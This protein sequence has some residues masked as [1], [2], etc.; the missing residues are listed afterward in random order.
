MSAAE[1]LRTLLAAVPNLSDK[2]IVIGSAAIPGYKQPQQL[3]AMNFLLANGAH[4]DVVIN[5]DG[6]NEVALAPSEQVTK[7]IWHFYPR[8]WYYRVAD[9]SAQERRILGHLTHLRGKRAELARKFSGPLLRLS[10]TG[11]LLWH[12]LDARL[13]RQSAGLELELL[14]SETTAEDY[15]TRGPSLTPD[16]EE[17]LYRELAE[18]WWRSSMLMN[19]LSSENGMRYFHF[20][21]PNQYVEGSKPLS[22]E[23]RRRAFRGR[24]PYRRGVVLGY[25]ELLAQAQQSRTTKIAFHDLTGLFEGLR[26]TLYVDSCCHFNHKGNRLLA[27]AVAAVMRE[28]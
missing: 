27:E 14:E 13:D 28:E 5:I 23:E 12:L 19:R 10:L 24:H 6:F 4:F 1:E 3:M 18:V 9:L 15:Q 26:E 8:D 11:G 21:Q 25:P 16:S 20:I 7:G 22:A 2:E 17:S